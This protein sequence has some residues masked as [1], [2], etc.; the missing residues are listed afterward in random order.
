MGKRFIPAAFG[1]LIA[2]A[3]LPGAAVGG[4]DVL[5]VIDNSGSMAG[6]DPDFTVREV[7]ADFAERLDADDRVGLVLFD[8]TVRMP[9]ALTAIEDGGLEAL[10]KGLPEVDYRGQFTD[11]PA[12]IERA[13]YELGKAGGENVPIVVFLTDGIV[14]TGN[15]RLDAERVKWLREDL[16]SEAADDG[17]RIFGIAFTENADSLLVQSLARRTGA[18]YFRALAAADLPRA[19]DDAF[20][21]AEENVRDER[22]ATEPDAASTREPL[23]DL[24]LPL[25]EPDDTGTSRD[26]GAARG[27]AEAPAFADP[28]PPPSDVPMPDPET[29]AADEKAAVDEFNEALSDAGINLDDIP[30]GQAIII[31]PRQESDSTPLLIA[32]LVVVAMAALFVVWLLWRRKA[33][34]SGDDEAPLIPPAPNAPAIEIPEAYLVDVDQITE[35]DRHP[36][37]V[38]SIMVGRVA[39][40]ASTEY[41]YLVIRQPTIG[42]QHA[43]IKYQDFAYWVVDQGSVNGTYVNDQRVTGPTRLKHGDVVRFHKTPFRIEISKAFEQGEGTAYD[44]TVM[45]DTEATMAASADALAGAT[46]ALSASQIAEAAGLASARA[47]GA[48]DETQPVQDDLFGVTDD[49]SVPDDETRVLAPDADTIP[50]VTASDADDAVKSF[51]DITGDEQRVSL[52]DTADEEVDFTATTVVPGVEPPDEDVSLVGSDDDFDAEASAFFDD[53][54]IGAPED[55]TDDDLTMFDDDDTPSSADPDETADDFVFIESDDDT[56]AATDGVMAKFDQATAP[57][58]EDMDQTAIMSPGTASGLGLDAVKRPSTEP[59]AEREQGGFE[60][61]TLFGGGG[62]ADEVGEFFDITGTTGEYD[63]EE[64][65]DES[66]NERNRSGDGA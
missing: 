20:A 56:S 57:P 46:A 38:K 66:S 1:A 49:L 31:P 30:E 10:E 22:P 55:R 3:A 36:L 37:H 65:D 44:A 21:A 35:R 15:A 26:A 34:G 4:S 14:D 8:K 32:A 54:T 23:V 58:D 51:F 5:F 24:S 59:A 11:S 48:G 47:P 62:S 18:D 25:G 52:D 64:D 60:Q 9:A 29:L 17:V 7:V 50:P 63:A 61:T 45:A 33:P 43:V 42:R 16:A 19:F 27:E 13:L 6:N 40:P 12:G 2:F 53:G 28:P 39:G 41:E